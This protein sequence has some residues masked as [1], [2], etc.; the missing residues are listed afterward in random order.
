MRTLA[1]IGV[2]SGMLS[3]MFGVGGLLA[4]EML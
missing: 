2:V 4:A 3:G 1:A